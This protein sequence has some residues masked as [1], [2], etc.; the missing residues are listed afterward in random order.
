MDGSADVNGFKEEVENEEIDVV[1]VVP[2]GYAPA[3]G[4]CNTEQGTGYPLANHAATEAAR[5]GGVECAGTG[6][7]MCK[8]GG[9]T[10][11]VLVEKS[12]HVI[13]RGGI[14]DGA[15]VFNPT[16]LFFIR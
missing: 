10:A 16:L 5:M 14:G 9:E 11:V 3:D 1:V 4:K 12:L 2:K 7:G 13:E 15:I 8:D 6:T